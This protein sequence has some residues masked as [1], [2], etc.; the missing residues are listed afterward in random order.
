V[1][2]PTDTDLLKA[3]EDPA[4]RKLAMDFLRD[5]AKY[6][7]TYNFKWLGRPVIQTPQDIVA[8]QELVWEVKPD[9]VVETGIAHGGSLIL[10]ASILELIGGE[11]RVVG[12]DI[13]IHEPNRKAIEAHRM[14]PRIHMIEGSST[15]P[16]VVAQVRAFAPPGT[17][18][19]VILD[20]NHTHEHV[21]AELRAYAPLVGAGSYLLVMDSTI[22]DMPQ[23]LYPDRPWGKGNN[24]KTA[25]FAFLEECDRFEIARD[26]EARLLITVASDGYLRCV[27]DPQ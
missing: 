5:S 6:G 7:Y 13:D 12:V 21:L 26:I 18:T 23:D 9:L 11:G 22:E 20:S 19:L 15:D 2:P 3:L 25:L 1:A 10:S 27:K 4:L 17:R 14:A 24:P 16:E 8:I